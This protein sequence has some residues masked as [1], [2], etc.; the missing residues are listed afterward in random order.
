MKN[1]AISFVRAG[2]RSVRA[3]GV[4]ALALGLHAALAQHAGHGAPAQAAAPKPTKER[5]P[6]PQLGTGAAFVYSVVATVAPQVFTWLGLSEGHHA[7]SHMGDGNEAGVR[8]F[9]TAERWYAEQF[10]RLMQ[11]VRHIAQ[12]IGREVTPPPGT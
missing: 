10:A 9:V 11:E 3:L 7:L 1:T 12:A 2:L 8:A 4:A 6:R 5:A